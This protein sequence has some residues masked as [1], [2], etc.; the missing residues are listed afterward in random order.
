MAIAE[1]LTG[2]SMSIT[3]HIS[4]AVTTPTPN[5]LF[6]TPKNFENSFTNI[7]IPIINIKFP[8]N[9]LKLK[10]LN[11]HIKHLSPFL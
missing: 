10:F 7:I 4:M 1:S 11:L 5:K 9:N 2:K 8:T 3:P 6:S